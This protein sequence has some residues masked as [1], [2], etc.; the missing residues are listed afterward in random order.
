MLTTERVA[1]SD[2]L[3]VSVH[4]RELADLLPRQPEVL[5]DAACRR[6]VDEALAQLPRLIPYAGA[7]LPQ[8]IGR[9]RFRDLTDDMEQGQRLVLRRSPMDG[10]SR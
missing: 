4:G 3:R 10:C 9:R 7:D 8:V 5:A 1:E 2:A 6:G